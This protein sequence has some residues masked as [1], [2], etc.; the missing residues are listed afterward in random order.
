MAPRI[1]ISVL[2]WRYLVRFMH[3][4]LYSRGNSSRNPLDGRLDGSQGR[5]GRDGEEK[6]IP[7]HAGNRIPFVRSNDIETGISFY[8][9]S[10]KVSE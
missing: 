6:K 2:R 3:Q 9:L 10:V 7:F 1:L 8:Q 4:P 5:S